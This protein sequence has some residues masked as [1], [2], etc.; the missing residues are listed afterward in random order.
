MCDYKEQF[1]RA[2]NIMDERFKKSREER[3]KELKRLQ[4]DI[5]KDVQL[6]VNQKNNLAIEYAINCFNKNRHIFIDD[7]LQYFISCMTEGNL[8][9][10]FYK[11]HELILLDFP[12]KLKGIIW[13][14][15]ILETI[16]RLICDELK[17]LTPDFCTF[18]VDNM[19]EAKLTITEG[20]YYMY[21]FG[22][23]IV[24]YINY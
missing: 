2:K 7:T 22:V 20:G 12:G 1:V 5:S 17:K 9:T 18:Y 4:G 23:K 14:D 19:D 21:H 10:P 3:D 24:M 6:K 13:E 11:C 8:E 16:R 15:K